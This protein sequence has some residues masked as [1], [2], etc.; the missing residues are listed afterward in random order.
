[1]E[2]PHG[3]T[4]ATWLAGANSE[5]A[6]VSQVISLPAATNSVLS[7]W[8]WL[9]SSDFC[10]YDYG[11]VRLI[12]GGSTIQLK[13]YNLCASTRTNGWVREQIDVSQYAGKTVTLV[14]RATTDYS[15]PSDFFVDDVSVLSGNACVAGTVSSADVGASDASSP[16]GKPLTP[17]EP[18]RR[19]P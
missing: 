7:Y 12:V 9:D 14:F 16:V 10:N 5:T 15:Y 13:R 8:Y 1:M 19:Q 4:W 11:Y 6:Q 18:G 17:E 3:G 2:T